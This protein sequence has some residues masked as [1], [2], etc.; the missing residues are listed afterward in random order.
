MFN[1]EV[2]LKCF[3]FVQNG[4]KAMFPVKDGWPIRKQNAYKSL[5]MLRS[6]RPTI[7]KFQKEIQNLS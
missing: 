6:T 2:C 4:A 3:Y 5:V 7:N 1:Q